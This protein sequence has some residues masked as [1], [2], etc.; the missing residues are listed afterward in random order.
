MGVKR[1]SWFDFLNEKVDSVGPRRSSGSIS[2]QSRA[3]LGKFQSATAT[4][5]RVVIT[6]SGEVLPQGSSLLLSVFRGSA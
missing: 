3:G 5:F 4:G 1:D 2:Y 6:N